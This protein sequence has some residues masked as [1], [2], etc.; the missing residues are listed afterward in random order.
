MDPLKGMERHKDSKKASRAV[1]PCDSSSFALLGI[2]T[3]NCEHR[4]NLVHIR[5]EK[6]RYPRNGTDIYVALIFWFG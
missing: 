5:G 1:K 6:K 4:N 3:N 2:V